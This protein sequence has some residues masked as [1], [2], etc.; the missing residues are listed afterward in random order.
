MYPGVVAEEAK[1][2]LVPSS[3]LYASFTIS[4]VIHSNAVALVRG[5]R[6]NT[7]DYSPVNLTTFGYVESSSNNSIASSVVLYKLLSRAFRE[8]CT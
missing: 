1:A 5:D 3:G 6:F 7:L 8:F 4:R 2:P